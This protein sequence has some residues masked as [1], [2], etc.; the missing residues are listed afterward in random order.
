MA[1][2]DAPSPCV[3]VQVQV[4]ENDILKTVVALTPTG[5]V[6]SLGKDKKSPI[7]HFTKG[8]NYRI[9][10]ACVS[11]KGLFQNTALNFT[12]DGRT[13]MVVFTESGFRLQRGGLA[14]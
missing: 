1:V 2:I 10:G 4:F 3:T 9:R 11:A 5:Q 7:P 8:K 13:V 14:Y 6:N 12:A